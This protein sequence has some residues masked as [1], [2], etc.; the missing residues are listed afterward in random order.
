MMGGG[1]AIRPSRPDDLERLAAVERSAATVYFEALGIRAGIP[2]TMPPAVL[3]ACHEA[4]L[5]WV[6]ADGS[7]DPVGFLAAA[8]VDGIPFVKE[9]S[10]H[11]DHQGRG[12]GRRLMEALAGHAAQRGRAALALTTDRFI[13]FNAPFYA[14]LG[15]VELPPGEAT[16][17]LRRILAEEAAQGFDP[18]R[19]VLMVRSLRALQD[20]AVPLYPERRTE[21]RS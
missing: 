18:R 4:G 3:R 2:E 21:E 19:R 15:F 13:P 9:M 16:E 10:V 7:G 8:E 20:G 12:L 1:Y 17:G 11:R 14:R 6:A 5:V